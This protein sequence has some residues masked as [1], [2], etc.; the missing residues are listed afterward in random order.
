MIYMLLVLL[1]GCSFG[2]L[3]PVVKLA[4]NSGL[5]PE[6]V[7]FTQFFMA[8][9]ILSC[10]MLVTSRQRVGYKKAVKLALAGV[11]NGMAGLFFFLSLQSLPA[12]IAIVIMFQFTWMGV[13]LEAMADRS[14][15]SKEK[16]WSV[17]VLVIGIMMAG[18]ILE[19][20]VKLDLI[21]VMFA[22]LSALAYALYILCSGRVAIDQPPINRSMWIMAGAVLF[23]AFVY[24]PKFIFEG[25]VT[26]N[27]IWFG[28]VIGLLGGVVPTLLLAK[29]VPQVGPGMATIL[30]SS[31]L[32]VAL[33]G[34]A[35]L[36]GERASILQWF[37]VGLILFGMAIPY[38]ISLSRR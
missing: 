18:G 10:L 30:C 4:Y 35:I 14:W 31:E 19:G 21:G 26:A 8:W 5:P 24:P 23:S 29:G 15:P 12:S 27:L 20:D 33:L 17:L 3:S 6:Q 37:G 1:A 16:L 28:L 32:P 7:V 13:L 22:S 2:L 11:S 36:L 38:L 9:L 25:Q 34:A